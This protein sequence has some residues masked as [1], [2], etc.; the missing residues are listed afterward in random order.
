MSL[1]PSNPDIASQSSTT[2]Y[3]DGFADVSHYIGSDRDLALFRRFDVL[4]ARNLLYLQARLLA[5][6]EVLQ[7]YDEEDRELISRNSTVNEEKEIVRS[8][9]ALDALLAAKDWMTFVSR[10]KNENGRKNKGREK[11]HYMKRM[12]MVL[13]LQKVVKEYR[14]YEASLDPSHL[15]NTEGTN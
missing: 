2:E 4:G 7:K 13:E 11:G 15:L 8:E 12:E 14:A 1:T 5:L 10:A 6:E 9:E 3:L